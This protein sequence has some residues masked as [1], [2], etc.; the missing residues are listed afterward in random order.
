MV[1]KERLRGI[2]KNWR[3][4]HLLQVIVLAA[5]SMILGFFGLLY[6]FSK[7][8]DISELKNELPQ[9]TVFYDI[10]GKVASKVSANKNEGVPITEIP[11]SMINAIVAIEDHRFYQHSGVDLIGT[12]RALFRDLKAG[13]MVEGGSTITQQLTKNTILTSEKTVKRKMEEVFLALAVEREYTKQE[14]LQMYLNQI[15]FGNGAYGIKQAASKYFAKEVKDLSISESAL[16][17]GLINAPSA[18]NPYENMEKATER[19]NLVLAKMQEQG[20]ITTQQAEK[21]TH[22]KVVLDDKGGDPFRGKFPYY[23]DQV[24]DEAIKQYGFTQDELLTGGYQIYTEL[25][26]AMQAAMENTYQN[27]ALFPKGK[28]LL[29]QSGG[30]LV[31]PKTGGI[32]ALVGG[33][34]DHAFRGYNRASQLKAQPGS[35]FKPLVVYTPALE[36]GWKITDMLKDEQM[37]FGTYEPSNYNHQYEGE[38][39][40]YEAVKESKNVSAVWLLNELG[41]EKGLDAVNRFGITLDKADRNLAIA[42]GGLRKGVSPIEM[43]E[44]FSVF[45]NNGVR[46]EAHVINKIIDAKGNMVAEWKG[47]N[48][49]VTTKAVTD[50]MTTM[51]LGVIELG[52]GKAAQIP[53]RETAGKTG[54]T[55]VP[56]QG[57][58]G[59]KDQWFVGYTPQLVGAIWVGYD[60]T[61]ADHYITPTS[62]TGSAVIFSEVM[63]E[64]LKGYPNESFNV[65]HIS[66]LIEKRKKEE[67]EKNL[68]NFQKKFNNEVQKWEE[69]WNKQKEKWD[70]KEKDKGKGKVKGKDKGKGH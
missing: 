6:Y 44:A 67:E 51:L 38:V 16:L 35:S 14:I 25:D 15:Y 19:R 12:S 30:V 48:E 4:W 43:A 1:L 8:A 65:P 61:D 53:G 34:G 33:R 46:E 32:R 66:S 18:L 52:T 10:N 29:V 69:K 57:I 7:D 3:K 27:D 50:N 9:P 5:L 39:P 45:P 58:N 56:I 23:V 55:Q 70:K 54:S 13:A 36:E 20:Y 60:K 63:K 68:N 37:K 40:M 62:G 21:A 2:F 41:I 26:P 17:A 47:K 24:L 11:N 31:D 28:D 42:L 49:R 64:A 22:E 59:L